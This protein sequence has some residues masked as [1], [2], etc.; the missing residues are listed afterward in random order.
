MKVVKILLL[1][2]AFCGS[3]LLAGPAEHPFYVSITE[4]H[5]QPQ[6]Q[7]IQLSCRMF[8]DDLEDAL[9]RLNGVAADLLVPKD[10]ATVNALLNAYVQARVQ[11]QVN[12]V[13]QQLEYIGYES[14]EEAVWVHFEGKLTETP[15]RVD[16]NN[17]LLFDFLPGQTNMLHCYLDEKRQ[18]TKL[19]C[20]ERKAVFQW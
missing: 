16:V 13:P 11:I 19:D 1:F 8:A 7:L 9:R 6:Q 18:S 17:S 14:D 10:E 2:M 20:P 15:G 5:I 3:R 12:G 4:I